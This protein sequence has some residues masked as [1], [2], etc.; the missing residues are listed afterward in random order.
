MVGKRF[1]QAFRLLLAAG[2]LSATMAIPAVATPDDGTGHKVTICHVTHSATN[3]Y[4]VITVDV[5]AF[6]GAGA[7]DHSRHEVDGVSDSLYIDGVCVD[8]PT[9]TPEEQD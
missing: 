7:N 1:R 6:D 8:G 9:D 5:A 3:P 4:V 2:L